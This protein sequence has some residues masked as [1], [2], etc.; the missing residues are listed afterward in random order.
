MTRMKFPARGRDDERVLDTMA[1]LANDDPDAD[2]N[3]FA[4]YTMYPGDH[5]HNLAVRAWQRYSNVN[6]LIGKLVPSLAKMERD[7]VDMSLDLFQAPEAAVGYVMSGG[8]ESLFQALYTARELARGLRDVSQPN[9]IVSRTAHASIEKSAYYLGIEVHRVDE[10]DDRT[11]DVDA[12]RTAIDDNTILL[13]ASAPAYPHGVFDP[14]EHIG[15]LATEKGIPFHVDACVGGFL[16]P[17]MRDNGEPIPPFDFAVPGV[18]SLS[19]DLHKYG[20]TTKGA[21]VILYRDA[22]LA[23]HQKIV[24]DAWPYGPFTVTT[25]AGSRPAGPIAAAWAVLH[26]LGREGYQQLAQRIVAANQRLI[27][28]IRSIDGLD[29]WPNEPELSIW[30]ITSETKDIRKI[31]AAMGSMGWVLF[32]CD[33][34]SGIHILGDPFPDE[35]ID[36]FLADLSKAAAM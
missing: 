21:S 30:L 3:R 5:V 23:E 20:Y 31:A 29:H 9:I 4:L 10:L 12:M 2:I 28:G 24:C 18:T 14:I 1:V 25:L 33:E 6:G 16:A 36:R 34:P 19:A 22:T 8:T 13:L 27:A 17:F 11:A 7:V 26:H 35:L 15:S 32:C